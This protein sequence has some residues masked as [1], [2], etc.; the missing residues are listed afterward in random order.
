MKRNYKLT[1]IR[2]YYVSLNLVNLKST[3][4]KQLFQIKIIPILYKFYTQAYPHILQDL[5]QMNI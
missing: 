3:N 5:K 1:L 4:L 2:I